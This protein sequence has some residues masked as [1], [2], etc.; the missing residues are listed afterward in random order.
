MNGIRLVALDMDG[1]L[2]NNANEITTENKEAIQEAV[3]RGIEVVISTGR[4]FVG[5]ARQR[6]CAAW[7][8]LCDHGKRGRGLSD[9]R[10]G[11]HFREF[12]G[13]WEDLSDYQGASE[14]GDSF[15]CVREWKTV[16]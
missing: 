11:V 10:A 15:Q 13:M 4:P 6:A 7:G 14:E 16:R 12:H 8:S 1:T 9:G 3:E 2:L 5:G